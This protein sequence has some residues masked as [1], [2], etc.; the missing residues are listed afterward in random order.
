MRASTAKPATSTSPTDTASATSRL[1]VGAM[2]PAAQ[3]DLLAVT[4]DMPQADEAALAAR[5]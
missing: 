5:Y 4:V 3:T 1:Y 2:T